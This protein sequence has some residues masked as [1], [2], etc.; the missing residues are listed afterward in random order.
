MN[1][2]RNQI[3]AAGVLTLLCASCSIF[4][5]EKAVEKEAVLPQDRE[6][7]Q[8]QASLKTFN[9][10]ELSRGIISGDWAIEEVY[11]KK[12]IGENPPFL[13]FVPSEKRVYGNDGCNTLNAE[14]T[15]S[16]TDS[17]LVFS[18]VL[19]TL[20][21]CGKEGITDREIGSAV[22]A[23]RFYSW[24]LK[25]NNY[26]LYTFDANHYPLMTLMHQSFDFLNGTWHVT[27]IDDLPVNNPEMQLVIDV[28][29]GKVHGNTGCNILN[30]SFETD[31]E[32]P[33]S[34]S[35][36]ALATTRMACPDDLAD[37]QTRLIV[38]LEDA[39]KAKPLSAGKVLF[40]NSSDEVVLTLERAKTTSDF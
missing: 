17:T 39:S 5:S 2:R 40:L 26:Y 22:D 15:Y 6:A 4:K 13:K 32:M 9:P 29:E 24:E 20:M 23:T 30:G 35:F 36:Q 27:A 18:N 33:N 8:K 14:Y 37:Y 21:Y 10:E 28:D 34:I 19:S 11:G 7:I 31:M 16:P 3:L 25:D 38:A 1:N 12:T